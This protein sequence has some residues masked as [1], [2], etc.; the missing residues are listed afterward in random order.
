MRQ[1]TTVD[2]LWEQF[3]ET[4]DKDVKNELIMHYLYIVGIV[5]GQMLPH[6][7][8][9]SEKD[10]LTSC[11]VVGLIDAINRFERSFGVKFQTYATLRIRGEILD[12]MRRQDWAPSS[13][14]KRIS[15][16]YRA[17]EVLEG[18][19]SRKPTQA[20][21][22]DYLGVREA[23]VNEALYKTQIF[24]LVYYEGLPYEK[25]MEPAAAPERN[26]PYKIVEKAIMTQEVRQIIETLPERKKT[27]IILHYFEG[28]TMK[29]IAKRLQISESRVSQI[30]A[31]ILMDMRA[32]LEN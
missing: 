1:Q 10:E 31:R 11:G 12:Y 23:A 24:S 28:L 22:A 4:G 20:E 32:A 2:E 15:S 21:I 7:R 6:Y 27:L 19:Y 16:I 25:E 3:F 5:V 30:H 17:G 14:R 9:F 18:R 13:L 26:D 8:Q 29:S